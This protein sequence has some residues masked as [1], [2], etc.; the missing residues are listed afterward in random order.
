MPDYPQPGSKEFDQ[1]SNLEQVAAR[2]E[3][4]EQRQQRQEERERA[5]EAGIPAERD[6]R[7]AME[8]AIAE[9]R[10]EPGR[11][12]VVDQEGDDE[13]VEIVSVEP[14]E[15]LTDDGEVEL[16]EGIANEGDYSSDPNIIRS[17]EQQSLAESGAENLREQTGREDIQSD[18][19]T[20]VKEDGDAKRVETTQNYA[21]ERAAKRLREERGANV[22][23][24]EIVQSTD[25]DQQ[26]ALTEE[27]ERAVVRAEQQRTGRSTRPRSPRGT[28]QRARRRSIDRRVRDQYGGGLERGSDY[29]VEERTVSSGDAAF[30]RT[31]DRALPGDQPTPEAGT[32][33]QSVEFTDRGRRQ[34][35]FNRLRQAGETATAAVGTA[36][37]APTQVDQRE[38]LQDFEP[39]ETESERLSISDDVSNVP[40][41]YRAEARVGRSIAE[42]A[43]VST[44]A[45]GEIDDAA[46]DVVGG[47]VD[48]TVESYEGLI[49]GSGVG[50]TAAGLAEQSTAAGDA[51]NRYVTQPA[52]DIAGDVV[53]V[54][55]RAVE[56]AGERQRATAG[57]A[58]VGGLGVDPRRGSIDS[59]IGSDE[60]ARIEAADERFGDAVTDL[61]KPADSEVGNTSPLESG[62]ENFAR[63]ALQTGEM[64]VEAPATISSV[65][66]TAGEA[67]EGAGEN[68]QE[69]GLAAGGAESAATG[70]VVAGG[71]LAQT[72]QRA[73]ANPLQTA[74][75]LAATTAVMGGAARLNPTAGTASRVAIQPGEE[76]IGY[77]GNAALPGRAGRAL[78][79][80]NEP[81]LISEEAAIAGARKVG[82]TAKRAVRSVT[83]DTEFGP[84]PRQRILIEEGRPRGGGEVR[85]VDDP[86]VVPAGSGPVGSPTEP[87]L[88][89]TTRIEPSSRPP[90]SF[91]TEA[92]GTEAPTSES[93]EPTQL[94][95]E[96]T[97]RQEGGARQYLERRGRV[98]ADEL[99][100]NVRRLAAQERAQASLVGRSRG[101]GATEPEQAPVQ[102][103]ETFEEFRNRQ[104]ELAQRR[105]LQSD[106]DRGRE[107]FV[108][109]DRRVERAQQPSVSAETDRLGGRTRVRAQPAT[110]PGQRPGQT[111]QPGQRPFAVAGPRV[112][113]RPVSDVRVGLGTELATETAQEIEQ[114]L[115]SEFER[116][117]EAERELRPEPEF[118]P[119]PEFEPE[120]ELEPDPFREVEYESDRLFERERRQQERLQ[121][122]EV[123]VG[124]RNPVELPR[125]VLF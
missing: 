36:V 40:Q 10:V 99:P 52:A 48:T 80:N 49:E 106:I 93:T 29:R 27:G 66:T 78:F 55:A 61:G 54:S 74:G 57:A 7:N 34:I 33:L 100:P 26:L 117:R 30:L 56:A 17:S 95:L 75:T 90:E 97:L 104:D 96:D 41:R 102:E 87:T 3:Y 70:A 92:A 71:M 8:Q 81:L 45:W 113:V 62:T 4:R 125:Q 91:A 107:P 73:A 115:E 101:R 32:R 79:P 69:E 37:A 5:K 76:L 22:T 122:A 13:P 31:V 35:R 53:D 94:P 60:R 39:V 118:E 84:T 20:V 14:N 51:V 123:S 24:D 111:Q 67:I 16:G 47:V 65:G 119:R 44:S 116:G 63:G 82:G 25:P 89:A 109:R 68:M 43:T 72:A 38:T 88:D 18:D 19:V 2:R 58:D 11:A 83:G 12:E 50:K 77:A 64:V 23:E 6:D 42:T 46:G 108:D 85:A 28:T 86:G 98:I 9:G 105:D 15:Q 120:P 124:F 114:P 112:G 121:D 59:G 103:P 21:E 110:Q 1:L